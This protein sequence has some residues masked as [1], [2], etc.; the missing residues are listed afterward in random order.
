MEN[1]LGMKWG[2]GGMEDGYDY[3]GVPQ[4]ISVTVEQFFI[5]I[6]VVIT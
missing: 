6:V 4:E 3:N 1:K 2:G 5:L